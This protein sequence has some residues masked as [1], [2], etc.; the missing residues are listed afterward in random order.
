MNGTIR[1]MESSAFIDSYPF[2]AGDNR[3]FNDRI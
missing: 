3:W 2:V 1:R